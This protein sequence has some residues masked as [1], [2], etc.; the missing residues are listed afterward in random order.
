M[1]TIDFIIDQ[2][3]LKCLFIACKLPVTFENFIKDCKSSYL[4]YYK[5]NSENLERYG[6]PKTYSQWI[7]GQIIALT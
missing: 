5:R 4:E 2:D 6:A 7:N 1:E 3:D